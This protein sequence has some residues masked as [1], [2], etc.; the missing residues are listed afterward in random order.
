M[1]TKRAVKNY[2]C[3]KG[4]SRFI[5]HFHCRKEFYTVCFSMKNHDPLSLYLAFFMLKKIIVLN[6]KKVGYK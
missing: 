6:N 1:I 5:D 4:G 2:L 3:N